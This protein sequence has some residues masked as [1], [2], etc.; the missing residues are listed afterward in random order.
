MESLE[1]VGRDVEAANDGVEKLREQAQVE[2][3]TLLSESEYQ[4]ME[5][6]ADKA[7]YLRGLILEKGAA[8]ADTSMPVDNNQRF[9]VE[10][11]ARDL[12]II[13]KMEDDFA[14]GQKVF[15]TA[16]G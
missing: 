5:T 10:L 8:V 14:K 1:Q 2:Y 13:E 7:G 9:L 12:T 16:K 15:A 4:S 11:L 6:L 3:D